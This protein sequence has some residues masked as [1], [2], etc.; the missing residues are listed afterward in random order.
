[1]K[2]IKNT[3]SLLISNNLDKESIEMLSYI[4]EIAIILCSI[5]ALSKTL[6]L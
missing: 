5:I 6:K 1:M 3:C 2:Y 4:L